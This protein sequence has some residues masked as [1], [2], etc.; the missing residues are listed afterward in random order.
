MRRRRVQ[1]TVPGFE[2]GQIVR[3][4]NVIASRHAGQLGRVMERRP[5]PRG[6]AS[7]DKYIVMLASGDREMF[8]S[9]QLEKDAEPGV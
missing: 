1:I 6:S 9:V 5:A 8:W 7:L 2:V 4:R 3:I